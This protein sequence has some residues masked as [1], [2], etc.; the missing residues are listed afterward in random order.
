[1]KSNFQIIVLGVFI[2]FA[3]LGVIL[4]AT[5]RGSGTGDEQVGSV[6]IWGTIDGTVFDSFLSEARQG[7]TDLAHVV[8]EEKDLALYTEQLTDAIASGRG[9]DLFVLPQDL[10]VSRAGIV[11]PISYDR[12]SARA[13]KS[14]FVQEGELY[15]VEDGMLGLPLSVDPQI[16][17]YNRN[18]LSTAG[19]A[20]VP[21]YWDEFFIAAP[22]I[23]VRD[24][25]GNITRSAVSFGE[26]RN[27]THAKDILA[28]LILQAASVGATG[29]SVFPMAGAFADTAAVEAAVRYYT[30]FSNPVKTVYSWNRA[31]KDSRAAFI[32]GELAFYVG[33]ASEL[34]S[35]RAANPNLDFDIAPMPQSRDRRAALSYGR[36]NALAIARGAQ[37]PV[38]SALAAL[39][40]TDR[41][42]A[43]HFIAATRTVP[44]RRDLLVARPDDP[45]AGILYDAALVSR[46]WFDPN[47]AESA[48]IFSSLVETVTSG[49]SGISDAV[50]TAGEEL[51]ALMDDRAGRE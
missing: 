46:G 36:M 25:A 1:M 47:P 17:Y 37:N 29:G 23:V 10:I 41:D 8:Y 9:P 42:T 40:L 27:V 12:M 51:S 19:I 32:A 28:T 49:R 3:V 4:F 20:T 14:T 5:Y 30:E 2:G 13:F 26:F 11:Q 50:R 35:I 6:T 45:Y 34:S 48:L 22:K 18:I 31:L 33:Y 24:R 16:L 15:L 7:R 39:V 38:G 43:P 44:A 21:K